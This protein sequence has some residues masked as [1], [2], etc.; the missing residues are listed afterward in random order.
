MVD[1]VNEN[2]AI[3]RSKGKWI[4]VFSFEMMPKKRDLPSFL[5]CPKTVC[6]EILTDEIKLALP[7]SSLQGFMA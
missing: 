4:G 6:E 5:R 3:S 7:K 2:V 1:Y